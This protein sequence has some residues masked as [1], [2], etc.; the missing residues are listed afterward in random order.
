MANS[1]F[2]VSVRNG[3][4]ITQYVF[5]HMEAIKESI[6]TTYRNVDPSARPVQMAH[7]VSRPHVTQWV[8][9]AGNV[10]VMAEYVPVYARAAHF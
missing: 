5:D 7:N 9:A 2:L 4:T 8:D 1:V 3:E 10:V 6:A